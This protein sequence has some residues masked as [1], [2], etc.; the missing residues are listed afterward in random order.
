MANSLI[1][2]HFAHD[3]SNFYRISVAER[4]S[5]LTSYIT[6]NVCEVTHEISIFN[7]I[8]LFRASDVTEKSLSASASSLL[9]LTMYLVIVSENNM[10]RVLLL[11]Q[12]DTRLNNTPK[13]PLISKF[14]FVS[15]LYFSQYGTFPS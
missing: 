9:S 12:M 7:H 6:G 4:Y 11:A 5:T 2:F 15:Q 13:L 1:N 14:F 3:F 8:S 10:I